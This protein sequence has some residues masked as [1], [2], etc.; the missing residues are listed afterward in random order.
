MSV[1]RSINAEVM[2]KLVEFCING[3]NAGSP[4]CK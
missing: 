2:R 3:K 4:N 1:M